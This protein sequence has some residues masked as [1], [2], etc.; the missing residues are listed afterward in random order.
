MQTDSSKVKV[1]NVKEKL[2]LFNKYWGPKIVGELNDHKVQLVKIKGKFI[3]H[4]HENEDELFIV[5]RGKLIVHFRD[6]DV[7][8]K[9]GEFVIVPHSIEHMTEAKE[10]THL[11]Y[12][13]PKTALNTGNVTDSKYTAK[14]QDK[15]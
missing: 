11:I 10:E 6:R 5:V 2:S 1:I 3:W 12:I 14:K 9:E 13:E 7:Q 8:V 15:I 4:H